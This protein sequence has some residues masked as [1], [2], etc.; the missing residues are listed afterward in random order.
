MIPVTNVRECYVYMVSRHTVHLQVLE[1]SLLLL[2]LIVNMFA[3]YINAIEVVLLYLR[4]LVT[5]G[6]F[7]KKCF[8]CQSHDTY[9]EWSKWS[10]Y[11]Y[12]YSY[13]QRS[14]SF[15]HL[16]DVLR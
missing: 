3:L 6:K 12:L 10:K 15:V 9:S 1:R 13:N 16:E 7:K 4:A 11:I 2:K 14:T 5:W 8:N